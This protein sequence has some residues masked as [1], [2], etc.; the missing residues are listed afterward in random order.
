ML[1][2]DIWMLYGS[3]VY[4]TFV[5]GGLSKADRELIVVVTSAHNHCLYCVVS[6]SALHRIYS[7]K[8]MLADQVPKHFTKHIVKL[9][10]TLSDSI[11]QEYY[12]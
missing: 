6:H 2:V 7:K 3:K 4:S 9:F 12:K 1:N 8:P 11:F 5:T 10:N